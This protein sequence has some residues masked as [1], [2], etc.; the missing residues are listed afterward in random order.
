MFLI[1]DNLEVPHGKPDEA[2]VAD[3]AELKARLDLPSYWPEANPDEYP[4]RD[5]K[6]SLRSGPLVRAADS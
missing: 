6:R 2:C 4:N 5:L 1:V 3:R